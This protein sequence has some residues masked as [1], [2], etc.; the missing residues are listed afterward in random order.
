MTALETQMIYS[1]WVMN[2]AKHLGDVDGAEILQ[3]INFVAD[4]GVEFL[5]QHQALK[6][7]VPEKGSS[8]TIRCR[9]CGE[10]NKVAMS[11]Y[12]RNEGRYCNAECFKNRLIQRVKR[13]RAL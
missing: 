11:T 1:I 7:A 2:R 6:S 10:P 5:E 13:P 9:T 3:A 4:Y 12:K 8:V